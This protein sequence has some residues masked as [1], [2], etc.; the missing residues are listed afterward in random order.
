MTTPKRLI[1]VGFPLEAVSL[2]SVHEKNVRHGHLST[3]HIWPARR[4]LAACRATLIGAL[5][6]DPGSEKAR[7][8]LY[9]R[10]AGKVMSDIED[11]TTD[12]RR[13]SIPKPKTV[14]G[15]LHWGRE[16]SSEL[17]WFRERI[18]DV[19]G[20]R[21][22]RVLDPFA[23]GGAIPL[24]AMRLGCEVEAADIN[25]VA[26]FL[27]RC[28]LE[29]PQRLAG[30]TRPL[31]SSVTG[32]RD[33]MRAYWKSRGYRGR[34]VE[35]RLAAMD[36]ELS[37]ARKGK[38]EGRLFSV[39]EP[40]EANLAW[41]VRAWSHQVLGQVRR[42][43][44]SRYP[45]YAEFEPLRDEGKSGEGREPRLLEPDAEGRVSLDPLN[46]EFD[47]AYLADRRKPRWVAKPAAA[48]LWARTVPCKRCRAEMPLL[49]TRWLCRR[50]GKRILLTMEPNAART[51]V[52][53]GVRRVATSGGSVDRRQAAEIGAGTT[54]SAGAR[55]PCCS[56]IMTTEDLR[57]AAR[58]G[59]MGEV[60]TAVVV[61]GSRSKEY[62][63]PRKEEIQAASVDEDSLDELYRD[64]PF[65][66]PEEK[67][68]RQRPSPN[69]RG[70]SGL[71]PYGFRSWEALFTRRQLLALG[72]IVREVRVA[73]EDLETVSRS[74]REAIVAYLAN[75]LSKTTDYC[76]AFCSWH[77]GRETLRDTF[78]RF[79]LPIVWDYCEVNPLARTSGGFPR[80]AEWVGRYLDHSGTAAAAA[81][82]PRIH[83]R[84]ALTAP[85]GGFDV[86]CTDPPYYDAIPYSDLMDFFHVWLR[87]VLFGVSSEMDDAFSRPLGP[88]WSAES[89]DGELVDQPGRFGSDR[90]ASRRA[91]E[92]GMFRAF[93][94]CR[95]S[96]REDGR[97][98]VVFANKQ[99]DAW[100][101]LVS[102]LIRAGFT[103]TGSWPIRTEMANKVA[104]GARLSSSVWLVCRRRSRAAA[105]GWD[106]KVLGEMRRSVVERLRVFWD[107]GLRGPDF[108]WAATGPA[109]E[110]FSR[111]PVVRRV[112][113]LRTVSEGLGDSPASTREPTKGAAR[114]PRATL[115]VGEFLREVR[116]MVVDFV[117]GRVLTGEEPDDARRERG[118]GAA[119]EPDS[120]RKPSNDEATAG[121]DDVTTYYLLHRQDYGLESI[122]AG[123]SILYAQS[124]GLADRDLFGVFDLL[125]KG[126]TASRGSREVRGEETEAGE[127][128]DGAGAGDGGTVRLKPW[129]RRGRKT[130][131]EDRGARPVPLIDHAHRLMALW[132]AGEE[133]EVNEYF[134]NRGL[135]RDRLFGRVLQALI[136]L[137]PVESE[138]RAL[139]ESVSKHLEAR[140]GG[141]VNPNLGAQ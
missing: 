128:D 3:L 81:S 99:P 32:D 76:S 29:Y 22:P 110:V 94:K 20:G 141:A 106:R 54:S 37:G 138:E 26:W 108:V 15:I 16:R 27:L 25:P 82:R 18:R 17:E 5:L 132:R 51:G 92:E 89:A 24:E 64:I 93:E 12:G 139:L 8:N 4:P 59:R 40:P 79:A 56:S 111:H 19:R 127:A 44:A 38:M 43:L 87:R 134:H 135:L 122:P 109:L 125:E 88:K 86:I 100:E 41:Q 11:D 57:I 2:D 52:E 69:A 83:A 46:D 7:K 49:K 35:G 114:P 23:G 136:E 42:R 91:Y 113:P 31:P 126:G 6:P 50:P 10:M 75:I 97:L 71:P 63:R 133:K 39:E 48:Y 85:S 116:R 121:L 101:T 13:V 55:C 62:R 117:V 66:L 58:D 130:A 115:G 140:A 107:A 98:I 67:L 129:K 102:A 80:M 60:M 90:T 104:G 74:W 95:E 103:V 1:E 61:K 21:P 45:V 65:G 137:A 105:P 124:C 84:S 120:R 53:F 73:A 77:N 68:E 28:A 47:G 118:G 123:A 72:S 9:E 70:V 78:A 14:G 112:A 96:L 30:R 119:D 36:G 33:F 131:R 34:E